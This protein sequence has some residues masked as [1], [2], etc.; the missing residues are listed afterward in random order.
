MG[1]GPKDELA[2]LAKAV[3]AELA[4]HDVPFDDKPFVGHI[5]LARRARVDEASFDSLPFPNP[6][7][8][9]TVTLFKSELSSEGATYKALYS[10]ELGEWA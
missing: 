5:T 9:T 7:T 10:A 1:V 4:S 8:A 3:R 2:A 6:A